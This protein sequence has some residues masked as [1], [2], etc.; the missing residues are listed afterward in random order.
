MSFDVKR[1]LAALERQAPAPERYVIAFSGGLDSSVLLHALAGSRKRHGK[2]LLAVHVDHGLQ[3][4]SVR[5]R[6]TCA[7]KAEALGVD[8]R[9][10]V[11]ELDPDTPG[12]LEAAAR[13]ARYAALAGHVGDG[14]WLLTAHHQDDQAETLLINLLRGSGP[15][16]LAGIG[17]IRP[18]ASGWLVRPLLDTPRAALEAHAASADLGWLDDPSNSD[19]R[20]DRNYL[21]HEILP[22][23]NARWPGVAARLARSA[24]LA[25]DAAS[26]LEQLAAID[27]ETVGETVGRLSLTSLSGLDRSRQR[28]VLRSAIRRAGLPAPGAAPLAAVL[29]ELVAAR[30]DAQP[31]V[32][33][34]GGVARRYRDRLYLDAAGESG[35]SGQV[36]AAPLDFSPDTVELGFGLGFLAR[37]PDAPQGLSDEVLG[38]RLDIRFRRGGESIRPLGQARTR[39]LKTLLQEAGVVPWMRQRLPL[40]YADG[41]LVAV[42]DLWLA[43]SASSA[44]GTAVEWRDHPPL[45]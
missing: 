39:R 7:Q 18:F 37:V 2:A 22:R 11:V 23:L 3:A 25:G 43:A 34:P 44:P 12:G 6:E 45:F 21:R 33:W 5:W 27:L 26:L 38:R 1:L 28:N 15:A 13:E 19:P 16:G 8:F 29:D 30:D 10:E 20:F 41:E 4:D 17:A 31:L 32:R 42:A 9:A 40:V 14:D 36:P 24:A 35:E